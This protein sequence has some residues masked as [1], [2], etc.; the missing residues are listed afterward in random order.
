MRQCPIV[1]VALFVISL[2]LP[3]S[4]IGAVSEKDWPQYR[5]PQRSGESAARKVFPDSDFGLEVA[6]KRP[7]GSGYSGIAV[8][9]NRAVTMFTADQHDVIAA[10]DTDTGDELWRQVLAEV[11]KGHTGSDDGPL[12]TPVIADDTVYGLGPRGNLLAVD[13]TSGAVRWQR[14]LTDDGAAAPYYGFTTSPL[15]AGE[16]LVVE[17]GDEN[18]GAITA[19]DRRNGATRWRHGD[20]SVSYESPI[21]VDLAG[22]QQLVAATRGRLFGLEPAT[23]RELWRFDHGLGGVL[24]TPIRT[25]RSGLMVRGSREVAVFDV[26]RSDEGFRVEERWRSDVFKRSFVVPVVH[27][28]YAYGMSRSFLTCVDVRDGSRVWRSRP[29][30]GEGLVLVD[31]YLA[32]VGSGGQLV[33][34]K[35]SPAGYQ[36]VA[37][38]ALFE[39]APFTEP[40]FAGGRFYARD[41]TSLAAIRIVEG[42]ASGTLAE[43]PSSAPPDRYLGALGA[44]LEAIAELPSGERS[45]HVDALLEGSEGNP[46]TEVRGDTGFAHLIYRGEVEDVAVVGNI[47]GLRG[48]QPLHR[49]SGTDLFFRSFRLDPASVWQY[50]LNVDLGDPGPDPG[51]PWTV[52]VRNDEWSVLA[53]PRA[54]ALPHL[55]EP[56][57]DLKRGSIESFTLTSEHR[58]GE[59]EIEVYLPNGYDP[60]G[61]RRYPLLI[62]TIGNFHQ[63]LAFEQTLDVL[64]G[65]DAVEPLVVAFVPR[66]SGRDH[67]AEPDAYVTMLV[68]EIL[69]QLEKRYRLID[70]RRQRALLGQVSGSGI[71]VY[72]SFMANDRFGKVAVQSFQ[73]RGLEG[74]FEPRKIDGLEA[75]LEV[76]DSDLRRQEGDGPPP[77]E[78]I[79]EVLRAGG[80]KVEVVEIGG[81]DGLA[82]WRTTMDQLL[83]ALFGTE[84]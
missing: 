79:I 61:K 71:A 21:L 30:G 56:P 29:P 66:A 31:G 28:G 60:S 34:A 72:S 40:S 6:W 82:A 16:L 50:Q 44:R 83:I 64:I 8:V 78:R 10:F 42:K 65:A 47:P 7:L 24:G 49:L 84:R 4:P 62:H 46:I 23:G 51:N 81:S 19:V 41:L 38:T 69:P 2:A 33:V 58:H 68:E 76:R 43:A 13:L 25:D 27:G 52:T 70:D 73:S 39:R 32:V 48:E 9:G 12:S 3:S 75:Y 11:Y 18:G 74:L 45:A 59:R 80:A 77:I 37:R 53:M 20:D 63:G 5:G 1:P 14:R 55:E 22:R 36:E 57:A 54:R 67:S 26:R 15:V 17:S 35:A